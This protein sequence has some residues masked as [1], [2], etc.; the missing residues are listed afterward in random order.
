MANTPRFLSS[1]R[2]S[3]IPEG[4]YV[5][6][7]VR[8]NGHDT[9]IGQGQLIP[10]AFIEPPSLSFDVTT[11]ILTIGGRS[12][13][14]GE[15]DRFYVDC[16]N[17]DIA[18]MTPLVTRA[19]LV[20]ILDASTADT[21]ASGL[22]FG[23]GT[24]I[25]SG[26]NI[27]LNSTPSTP[28]GLYL[29][30]LGLAINALDA[31]NLIREFTDIIYTTPASVQTIVNSNISFQVLTELQN[32]LVAGPNINIVFA[33]G[34]EIVISS[35]ASGG[36]VTANALVPVPRIYVADSG[37]TGQKLN[38]L[39]S[40]NGIEGEFSSE[41]LGDVL[42]LNTMAFALAG[43]PL[44]VCNINTPDT[45][46]STASIVFV[47]QANSV[48]TFGSGNALG[49]FNPNPAW[50]QIVTGPGLVTDS[51]GPFT[52]HKE[53]INITSHS[54]LFL[55]LMSPAKVA[56]YRNGLLARITERIDINP[57]AGWDIVPVPV[58]SI[59]GGHQVQNL[60]IDG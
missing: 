36:T 44:F 37:A 27:K 14:L 60:A 52:L 2:F 7:V 38:I 54:T 32:R 13:D 10:N 31:F 47:G 8:I 23:S 21:V 39:S 1:P 35:T 57:T 56:V 16:R 45:N 34:G 51:T 29:S 4:R 3:G 33:P 59:I 48:Y 19:N 43:I 17:A 25:F 18:S 28:S 6:P 40:V 5:V 12:V 22:K 55:A 41:A 58:V 24:N 9:D 15:Q 42:K 49:P 50:G 46:S 26:I 20:D 53:I 11:G 30:N